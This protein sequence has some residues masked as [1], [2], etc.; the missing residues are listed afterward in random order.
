MRGKKYLLEEK[1][2]KSEINTAIKQTRN[3]KSPG[4]DGI[5]IEF[6]KHF[7]TDIKELLYNVIECVETMKTGL[8]TLIPKSNK[9]LLKLETVT[10]FCSD[11]K[12]LTLVYANR[13]KQVLAELVDEYQS[14]FIKGRNILNNVSLILE[15]LD[16]QSLLETEGFILFIDFFSKHLTL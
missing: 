14:A 11:Y 12:I 5:T 13:L 2:S 10:L 16:Y 9:D 7:W 15:M 1:L 8:I 4:I 3:G 6:Y